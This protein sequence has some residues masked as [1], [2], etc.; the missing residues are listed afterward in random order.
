[1]QRRTPRLGWAV[2]P[3][4]VAALLLA[5]VLLIGPQRAWAGLQAW[6]G[7]VPGVGFVDLEESRLLAQPASVTLSA[8]AAAHSSEETALQVQAGWQD[9]RWDWNGLGPPNTDS[10]S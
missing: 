7:Y 1:M 4:L 9:A 5:S 10:A 6:L 2:A 8:L 3:L